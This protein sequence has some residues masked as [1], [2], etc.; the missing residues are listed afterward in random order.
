MTHPTKIVCIGRSFRAH[1]QELGNAVP[2][3]P[4]FFLKAPSARIESGEAIELP[5]ASAMVHHEAEAAVIIGSRLQCGTLAEAEAAIEAWTVLNDVTARDLQKADKGRFTR[6]KGFDTFCPISADRV[7]PPLDWRQCRIQ[8]R[9]N[10]ELRQ[11]APLE[12]LMWS[13]AELLVHVSAVMTLFPGDIVSLGTPAGVG[14]LAPG[15][16]VQVQL[17]AP[18][19]AVLATVRN[20]VRRSASRV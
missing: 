7:P 8:G 17:L 9:V 19:G 20:P 2:E 14:P 4:I 15:D 11:D 16:T 3:A 12:Q 6:A 18:D 10:G 1:A 13:P 5:A